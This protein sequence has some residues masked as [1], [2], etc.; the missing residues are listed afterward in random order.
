MTLPLQLLK[1]LF[2]LLMLPFKLLAKP[3]GIIAKPLKI[4]LKPLGILLKPFR[5]FL[6]KKKEP[7]KKFSLKDIRS[8]PKKKLIPLL[9]LLILLVAAA[10]FGILKVLEI[11]NNR[12]AEDVVEPEIPPAPIEVPLPVVPAPVYYEVVG[13]S[14]FALPVG[15]SIEVREERLDEEPEEEE[16]KADQS[17]ED[18]SA[19]SEAEEAEP[20]P[21][22]N[23]GGL[24]LTEYVIYHYDFPEP[25]KRVA[26]YCELLTQEDMGFKPVD[27]KVMEMEIE[28]YEATAGDVHLVR[29]IPKELDENGEPV[30]DTSPRLMS[31]RIHWDSSGASV[32]VSELKGNIVVP[33]PPR[34]MTL[35]Q[36]IDFMYESDP[37]VLGLSGESMAEY[38]IMPMDGAVL[39]GTTPCQRM[40]VYRRDPQTNTYVIAG[41]YLLSGDGRYLYHVGDDGT[42][43]AVKR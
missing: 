1:K 13:E 27:K 25:Q 20:E 39:V 29:P 11:V 24:P 31:L 18:P 28:S 34:P 32:N 16:E 33:P 42:L 7:G 9:L 35:N 22:P 5:R 21:A 40:N 30:G 41:Q 43:E 17:K 23:I 3:L 19:E 6:P 2:G 4:L 26:A 36:A 8:M 37:A 14:I 15:D 10:V 38:D 12:K